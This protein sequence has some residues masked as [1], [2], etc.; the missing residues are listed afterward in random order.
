MRLISALETGDKLEMNQII[1]AYK[2]QNGAVNYPE[3]LKIP[4]SD[5]IVGLVSI[6]GYERVHVI[7]SVGIAS[8]L[9]SMNLSKPLS[10]TQIVDL[11]DAIIDSATEDNLAIEDVVLFLQK[12]VRGEAGKFYSSMDIPK[13]MEAFEDYRQKRHETILNI[14]DEQRAQYSVAGRADRIPDFSKE[15]TKSFSDHLKDTYGGKDV[16][17]N[18]DMA[19]SNAG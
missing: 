13:F 16:Q 6:G 4:A 18:G 7:L 15:D 3:V 9:E 2:A 10:S 5:R 11:S 19:G 8:A 1:K 17:G 14:R 12:M